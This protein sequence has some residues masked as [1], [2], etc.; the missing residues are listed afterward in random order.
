MRGHSALVLTLA[1][2][3]AF[4]AVQAEAAPDAGT[5]GGETEV[6]VRVLD[7]ERTV[8]PGDMPATGERGFTLPACLL[9][10]G[11]CVTVLAGTACRRRRRDD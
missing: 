11:G 1:L 3:L 10:A 7:S 4:P 6:T 8:T 9:V 5:A 2:A